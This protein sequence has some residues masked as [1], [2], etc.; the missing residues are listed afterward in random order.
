MKLI[1]NNYILKTLNT[2]YISDILIYYKNNS[3]FHK[4]SMPMKNDDF[5][6]EKNFVYMIQEEEKL[7][8][9]GQFYRFFIFRKNTFNI[10]G[11]VSI[12]D[13]RY[14]NISSCFLGIKIDKES[15][16]KG[17]ASEVLE[18]I[19]NFIKNDLKLHSIRATILPN[20]SK[21][22]SLFE[23]NGFQFDGVI[24]HLFKSENG[25]EDHFLYSLILK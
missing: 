19:I 4:F 12:Y 10:L 1:T 24:R 9:L 7:L 18:C 23:K 5:F 8:N 17:I 2:D 20:N 11:D 13:I 14:G 16:N 3:D 15:T 22:I 21:S 6:S 25:W